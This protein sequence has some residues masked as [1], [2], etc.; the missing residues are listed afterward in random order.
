MVSLDTCQAHSPAEDLHTSQG[1]P[2]NANRARKVEKKKSRNV[3][4]LE[5]WSVR[6]MVETDGLIEVAMVRAMSGE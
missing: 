4:I 5:T 1:R 3:C 6:L 2:T